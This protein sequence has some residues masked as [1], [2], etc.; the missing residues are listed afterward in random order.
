MLTNL[1]E[2]EYDNTIRKPR[3]D[4]A[5]G[6]NWGIQRT[7]GCFH[8]LFDLGPVYYFDTKGNNGIYPIMLQLNMGFDLKKW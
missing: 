3:S 1:K 2:I 5:I 8:L 7:L 4:Y 6:P